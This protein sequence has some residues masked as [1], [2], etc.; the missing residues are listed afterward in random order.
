MKVLAS[1]LL[2][3]A[4]AIGMMSC[5]SS[6][7]PAGEG[8]LSMETSIP[9]ATVQSMTIKGEHAEALN[10]DSVRVSRVRLLLSRIKLQAINDDS[11]TGGRDVKAGPAVIT[12]ER[13]KITSVFATTVPVGKYDR[14]KLESHRLTPPEV[15][16][17][18]GDAVFGDFATTD[19]PTVIIEGTVWN[20]GVATDF[21]QTS[22][23]TENLTIKAEPYFEI[24]ESTATSLKFDFDAV[25]WLKVGGKIRDPR[26]GDNKNDLKLRLKTF[27]K[28]MRK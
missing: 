20:G 10:C 5:K 26:D 7:S 17:W 14:I 8:S 11:G 16:K 15:I 3:G 13:G 22:D 19:R 23:N 25:E 9:T 24:T 6:T 2:V 12:F 28:L 1:G 21:V 27:F 18:S 4:L